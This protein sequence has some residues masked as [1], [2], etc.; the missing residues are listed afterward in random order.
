M[1]I[2]IFEHQVEPI[3]FT[4]RHFAL[5]PTFVKEA[6]PTLSREYLIWFD[7]YETDERYR[8]KWLIT[9]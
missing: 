3:S 8:G 7:W 1:N 9:K 2:K 4:H 5:F 6:H